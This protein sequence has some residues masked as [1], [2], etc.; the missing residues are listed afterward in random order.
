MNMRIV[1]EDDNSLCVSVIFNS[2]NCTTWRALVDMYPDVFHS[3]YSVTLN[4]YVVSIDT[5]LLKTAPDGYHYS[6]RNENGE[7]VVMDDKIV[8]DSSNSTTYTIYLER[9]DNQGTHSGGAD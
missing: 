7:Y 6:L 8:F 3:E 1:F 4:R 2:M 9:N 5:Q